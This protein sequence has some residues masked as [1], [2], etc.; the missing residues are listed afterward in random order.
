MKCQKCGAELISGHLYC[1][2]CGSEYQIV[3]DFEPEIENSIAQ[4][5]SGISESIESDKI[6]E[7]SP[8]ATKYKKKSTPSFSMILFCVFICSIFLY[9]GYSK[10]IHST[11]YQ[12]KQALE[13]FH[14]LDYYKA[15]QIYENLR[16]SNTDDAY[17]YIKE[18]E[19]KLILEK[20][21]EAYELALLAIQLNRN[22][23]KAYEF[24]ISYLEKE[25]NYLEL[26]KILQQCNYND[27]KEKYKEYLCKIPSINYE[28]GLY[29][30]TLELSF[31]EDFPG[32]IYY[33]LDNDMEPT[34]KSKEYITPIKLGNGQHTL[35]VI[36]EN[37]YGIFSD[38]A[39]YEYEIV[40]EIPMAP[41]VNLDSG[42]YHNAEWIKIDIED[43]TRV[44]YTTDL[45]HPTQ[46]SLEYITP[47]PMP[48]GE[49][50]FNFIAI[51]EKGISG[52]VTQRN[53]LLDMK[54]GITIEE[55]E[56]LLVQKLISIGHILDKNGAVKDRYGVF[57]YF[58]KFP[59][60]ETEINY[61]V[62]EEH[63][64][65][66]QINNPLKHFY[67]V[68]VIYGHVYKLISDENGN[69]TR[70]EI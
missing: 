8:V 34:S 44:Y 42:T 40:S 18:A 43:G 19:M 31:E 29:H 67:A 32:T 15:A 65:E 35:K 58:Y 28:S 16:K 36:Y 11:N 53:F 50:H 23:D 6:Q 66:N 22:T 13:A 10:Y 33:T 55:A 47:I 7:V 54:I 62:F 3:P 27:I 26:N 4:S 56:N 21:E 9:L 48:L 59:I 69:F 61:Y 39:V 2:I 57:R 45:T 68:D 30:E 46:E 63:Y 24:L 1:D 52:S 25:K 49:S 70:I 38:I 5:M 14:N 60:S 37:A 12:N 51:S 17:W 64:L 41:I 20:K